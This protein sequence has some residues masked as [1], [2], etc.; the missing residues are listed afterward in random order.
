MSDEEDTARSREVAERAIRRLGIVEWVALGGAVVLALV[1][2]ALIAFLLD[3]SLGLPFR[4]TWAVASLLIF[5]VPAAGIR[6]R[7]RRAGD[8][9]SQADHDERS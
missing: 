9:A 3:V 4:V 6:W 2:G 8:S 7:D 5:L 1:G